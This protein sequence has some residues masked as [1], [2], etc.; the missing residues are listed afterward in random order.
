MRIFRFVFPFAILASLLASQPCHAKR[1]APQPAAPLV[2][3]KITF[4]V[5][6]SPLGLVEAVDS[7]RGG[8]LWTKQVYVTRYD[9]ALERDV[10][11][12]FITRLRAADGGL[13]VTV[14]GGAEY[15]LDLATL[16]VRR[17]GDPA[18]PEDKPKA[19]R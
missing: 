7:E 4:R 9:P 1:A 15:F 6:P 2:L 3:G 10:Q 11:D 17:L 12:R 14:E 13:I 16:A 8:T 18:K 5:P 19:N